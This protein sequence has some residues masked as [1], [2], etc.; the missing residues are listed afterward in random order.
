MRAAVLRSTD[1][2]PPFAQSRPLTIEDVELTP[3]GPGQVQL[4]MASAG[5]CHSDLSVITGT[6]AKPVP[7]VAGHEGAG[8]VT[9]VGRDV[10]DIAVS[11]HV[12]LIFVSACGACPPC[13]RGRPALC[14]RSWSARSLGR[15]SDGSTHLYQD[16]QPL[17][18]W[19]GLSA[20]AE[21]AV[22]SRASVVR[23]DPSVPL[24]DGAVFGCA[25]VTGVGAV[26]H[27]AGVRPG[28][29][30]A[31]SGLGGVGLSAVMGAVLAG[32]REVIAVDPIEHKRE[33]AASLGAT[34]TVDAAG[35]D[36]AEHVLDLTD[37]GVD[38]CFEMSGASVAIGNAYRMI[39]R[40]GALV[41]ASLPAPSVELA[42]PV[43]SMVSDEKRVLGSYMGSS[44]PARDIPRYVALYRQGRLPVDRLRSSVLRLDDV[45]EGFDRLAEG[46][47]VRDVIDFS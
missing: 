13:L 7:A 10:T 5:L 4:R 27:T 35:G 2:P 25:V 33:L 3:P 44:V 36:A 28:D 16:G 39:R 21:E 6:R 26:L 14:E 42:V 37:G 47:A 15:L 30:V 19:S 31:V 11:D 23:I 29:T 20:F 17:H 34:K 9:A 45:N 46:R 8:V 32:A 43:A 18:H 1:H 41:I 38:H 22:V 24:L 12:V 40:G